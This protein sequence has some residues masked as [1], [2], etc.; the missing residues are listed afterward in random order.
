MNSIVIIEDHPDSVSA[1]LFARIPH[2]EPAPRPCKG[3][4]TVCGAV[5]LQWALRNL[6]FR[7][8]SRQ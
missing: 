4:V 2:A 1:R 6:G 7:E 5:R 8:C 3:A